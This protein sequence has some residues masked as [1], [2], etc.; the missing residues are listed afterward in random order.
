MPESRRAGLLADRG[1]RGLAGGELIAAGFALALS[2]D[3]FLTTWYGQAGVTGPFASRSG[4]SRPEN[5]WYA[6]STLRWLMLATIA[7]AILAFL[8]RIPGNP[9]LVRLDLSPL[10][11]V[12]GSVTSVLL[13]YRVLIVL[14]APNS[15]VDQKFGAFIGLLAAIGVAYGGYESRQGTRKKGPSVVQRSRT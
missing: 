10:V 15:V 3:M 7:V 9:R 6:L 14:P 8:V 12:L 11:V 4:A 13:V 1:A 2:A 5:A